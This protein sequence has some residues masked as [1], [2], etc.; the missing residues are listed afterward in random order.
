MKNVFMILAL[1]CLQLSLDAQNA[2]RLKRDS[3]IRILQSN[4][5]DTVRVKTQ[6]LLSFEMKL[7]GK[8][9]TALTL[10]TS[11]LEL[12]K[13]INFTRGEA[14]AH[15]FMGQAYAGKGKKPP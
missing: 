11:S 1:L 3:L 9:D 8:T 13:K 2:G 7:I 4:P 12:A 5:H 10:T 6:N 14:D 15:Y